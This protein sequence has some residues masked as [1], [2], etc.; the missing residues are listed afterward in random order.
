MKSVIRQVAV[1]FLIALFAQAQTTPRP[2]V[3]DYLCVSV[4]R[5]LAI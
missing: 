3:T 2:L 1:L 5:W 4:S